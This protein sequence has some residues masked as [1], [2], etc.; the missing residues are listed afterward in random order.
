MKYRLDRTEHQ[1]ERP[2]YQPHV[3]Y[4]QPKSGVIDHSHDDINQK[5]R[6]IDPHRSYFDRYQPLA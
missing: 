1:P 4:Y 5:E 3:Y 2:E 6:Y